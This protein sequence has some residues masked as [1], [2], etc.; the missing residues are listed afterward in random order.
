MRRMFTLLH[1]LVNLERRNS[2]CCFGGKRLPSYTASLYVHPDLKRPQLQEH[3]AEHSYSRMLLT[4]ES[5]ET[6]VL[7]LAV[8]GG[9]KSTPIC[10]LCPEVHQYLECICH[11]VHTRSWL[12]LRGL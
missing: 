7:M 11:C 2:R 8:E 10:A 1:N 5:A 9:V 12:L 4:G 3:Q 6:V